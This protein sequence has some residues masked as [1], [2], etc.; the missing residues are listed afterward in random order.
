MKR[1]KFT[2]K[3]WEFCCLWADGS[4]SWERM[5]NLKE[6][7]PIELANYADAHGLLHEPAFAWWANRM[8]KRSRR[9]IQK[10]K[11]HY[12]QRMH[13]YGIR[14]PKSIAEALQMDKENGNSLWHEAIQKE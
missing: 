11:T 9:V 5:R 6:S 7:N 13:K 14:L 10:V 2:T 12:W 3:G 1:R 4:T 8:L